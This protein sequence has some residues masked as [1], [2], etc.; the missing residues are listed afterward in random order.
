MARRLAHT[1]AQTCAT[2]APPAPPSNAPRVLMGPVASNHTAPTTLAFSGTTDPLTPLC[3]LL[4]ICCRR[5]RRRTLT[6]Q[7]ERPP[8]PHPPTPH[9]NHNHPKLAHPSCRALH[10]CPPPACP[11]ALTCPVRPQFSSSLP[12]AAAAEAAP[13]AGTQFDSAEGPPSP[14]PALYPQ[15]CAPS[16]PRT[17]R[18]PP[19]PPPPCLPVLRAL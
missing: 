13:C 4:L 11:P 5:P 12:A 18:T 14:P 8:S 15:S 7:V 16:V 1:P 3:R 2:H 6:C 19:P 10:A 17:R 9:H